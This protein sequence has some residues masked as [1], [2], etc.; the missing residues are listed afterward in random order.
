MQDKGFFFLLY[1]KESR[2]RWLL[3][4]V[5]GFKMSRMKSLWLSWLSVV[6]LRLQ[7]G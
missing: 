4:V 7:D 2:Y 5:V 3:E 1:N 6:A